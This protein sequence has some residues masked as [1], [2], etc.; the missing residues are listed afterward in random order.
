MK[1]YCA[2]CG[3]DCSHAYGTWMGYPYHFSCIPERRKKHGQSKP[4][5]SD[6]G[7]AAKQGETKEGA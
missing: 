5:E 6:H 1:T 7:K 2:G 4:I 3:E